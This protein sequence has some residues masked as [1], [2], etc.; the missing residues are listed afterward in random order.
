MK[1]LFAKR[2][3]LALSVHPSSEASTMATTTAARRSQAKRL[4][5][6]GKNFGASIKALPPEKQKAYAKQHRQVVESRQ[7]AQADDTVL[8]ARIG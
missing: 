2:T 1:R 5:R 7:R 3:T 8:S 4:A 6:L